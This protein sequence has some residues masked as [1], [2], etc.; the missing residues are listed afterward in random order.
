MTESKRLAL[1]LAVA[2]FALLAVQ[3]WVEA[4]ESVD[5]APR[6]AADLVAATNHMNYLSTRAPAPGR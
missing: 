3:S 6:E 2:A 5:R 4:V 1:L